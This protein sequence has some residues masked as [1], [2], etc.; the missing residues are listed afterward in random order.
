MWDSSTQL[1]C[2]VALNKVM[3]AYFCV[4][5]DRAQ[6]FWLHSMLYIYQNDYD[7]AHFSRHVW[8]LGLV[9]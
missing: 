3:D 1:D 8:L 7:M 6:T 4:A 9:P 5:L 2:T